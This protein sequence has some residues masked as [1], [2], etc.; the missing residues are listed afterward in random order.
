MRGTFLPFS[1]PSVGE[2]EITEVLATLRSDWITTGPKV[3]R[4]EREF[5]AFVDAPAALAV[6]SGTAAMHLALASLGIGPGDEVI[7]TPMTFCSCIHVIE[8]VGARPLLVDVEPDTL[9][10]DPTQ[11]DAAAERSRAVKAILPVHL[12]GHPSELDAL[13]DVASHY[14]L[15]LIEDAAHA[16]PAQYRRR[17][18][19]GSHRDGAAAPVDLVAFSFYATKNLTTAEGG[20]L[21]GPPDVLDRA[22][23]LSLH[24]MS[25][26]AYK[27]YTAEG[28]WHYNVV[29]AGFK[30]NMTDI[31]ASLGIHQLRRLPELQR[32]RSAIVQRYNEG[33]APIEPLQLPGKRAHVDHAWHLY[34]IR[35]RTE[36]LKIDRAQFIEELR[37]LN[38]GASVHF[39]PIHLHDYYRQKYG[40]KPEDFPIAYREFGRIVSLPLYPRMSDQDVDDVIAAVSAIFNRHRR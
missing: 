34:V 28:S 1:P 15:A 2:E 19:G 26:D 29:A 17:P 32:R 7:S 6:S 13:L 12:Y 33:L 16:L 5:A 39:I 25:R 9:N 38:I 18:I 20:M 24:G 40:F 14:E 4:F 11:V 23:I 8:Q 36:L 27:R 37:E 3:A 31:Q 21:T 30:Y 22:R 35:L 10:I